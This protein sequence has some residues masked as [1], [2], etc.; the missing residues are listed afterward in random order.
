[1]NKL[2]LLPL[3]LALALST[4]TALADTPIQQSRHAAA[5]A[6]VSITNI[7]GR[8][9]V[10]GWKRD[11]V[12]I[13]GSLGEGSGGLAISGDSHHLVIKVKGPGKTS[14]WFNWG[15]DSN[16]GPSTLDVKV[17]LGAS[18]DVHAVSAAVKVA[19]L[20]G[21]T[22]NIKGISGGI[23]V[24]A[25]VTAAQ[26]QNVSGHIVLHG[27]YGKADLQTVSGDIDARE[28]GASVQ[29]QTV[30]GH[31]RIV[32]GPFAALDASSV[33]GNIDITGDVTAA[34]HLDIDS[35][36]GDVRLQLPATV[37]AALHGSTFSGDIRSDFGHV[38]EK[39]RGPG[40][41]LDATAGSGKAR[42]KAH[43]FSGN[44]RIEREAGGH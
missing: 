1:M 13:T 9:S 18:L 26:V 11:Q 32:G 17:P 42:I 5:D 43:T 44:L 35:M 28:L 40:A 34:G 31:S 12:G 33:S 29:V 4:T 36:S 38:Q 7:S 16:M 30:S 24:D 19:G 25:H 21:G 20:D 37:S 6:T 22:I 8:I 3:T 39:Q 14:G 27:H 2:S 10:S 23:D 15:S 41:S